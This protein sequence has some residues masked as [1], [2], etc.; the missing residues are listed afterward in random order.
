MRVSLRA[1]HVLFVAV[2]AAAI[3]HAAHS[4]EPLPRRARRRTPC[5]GGEPSAVRSRGGGRLTRG[6]SDGRL[7]RGPDDWR[8]ST[9][10]GTRAVRRSA[11]QPARAL[12][13]R[14]VRRDRARR[15]FVRGEI[16]QAAEPGV[17]S[18]DAAAHA[19]RWRRRRRRA[20]HRAAAHADGA[21]VV[22]RRPDL[23]DRVRVGSSLSGSSGARHDWRAARARR[24][25]R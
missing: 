10:D 4:G 3:R 12:R 21:R 16:R 9:R 7:P 23:V 19:D 15:L 14:M 8:R 1:G 2:A 6:G 25:W 18:C 17:L 24:P 5:L 13:R 11:V 20:A 22:G